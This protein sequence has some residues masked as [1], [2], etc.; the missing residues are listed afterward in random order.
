MNN[1]IAAGLWTQ[2]SKLITEMS[3]VV[4]IC[5]F[6]GMM[7]VIIEFFQ[8]AHNI[9]SACGATLIIFSIVIRMLEGGTVAML[10]MMTFSAFIL[11]AA[12]H[13]IMLFFTKSL[14]LSSK[15]KN[16][17][18]SEIADSSSYAFLVNL[19][20]FSTTDIS[21]Q[22]HMS[23][24]DINFFVTSNERIEKGKKVKVVDVDGDKI[25]VEK[26]EE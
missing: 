10:F 11:V 18:S 4:V 26:V 5:F 15:Y 6:V 22:G 23:I 9:F 12:S 1:I 8:P 20:G 3:I 7:F 13:I 21:P 14:W 2:L 17:E 25:L 16:A 19:E 24:N